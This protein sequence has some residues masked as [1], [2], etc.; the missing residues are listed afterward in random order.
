[1][2]PFSFQHREQHISKRIY[3]ITVVQERFIFPDYNYKDGPFKFVLF[4]FLVY[5]LGFGTEV[6]LT[7][8]GVM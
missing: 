4:E 8:F 3:K 5:I 2:Q 7:P 6:W 1:M